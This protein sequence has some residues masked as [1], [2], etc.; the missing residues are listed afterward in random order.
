MRQAIQWAG[1]YLAQRLSLVK[2]RVCALGTMS[3]DDH[4][5]GVVDVNIILY[6][7]S[8]NNSK[9]SKLLP[10]LLQMAWQVLVISV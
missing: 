9:N 6:N 1:S 2:N 4:L 8:L 10:K 5:D 7:V 3:I